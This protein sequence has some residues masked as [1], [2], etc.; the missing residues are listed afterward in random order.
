MLALCTALTLMAAIK[1]RA[2]ANIERYFWCVLAEIPFLWVVN[3]WYGDRSLTY[4]CTYALFTAIILYAIVRIALD[5]LRTR[6]YKLR[7]VSIAFIFALL[8]A[9]LAFL[10]ASGPYLAINIGEEFVLVLAGIL[11]AFSSPYTSRPDLY[12]ILGVFWLC[13][14]GFS[15]GWVLNW[16]EW[17]DANWLVPPAMA[18]V[19]FSVLSWRL[20]RGPAPLG[21][22]RHY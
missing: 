12:F 7:S 13:Q 2:P 6:R 5:C 9:R 18:C 8:F 20:S 10:D 14:A 16:Q 21:H 19:A 15:L 3:A 22:P 1:R 4:A 11:T 17:Q